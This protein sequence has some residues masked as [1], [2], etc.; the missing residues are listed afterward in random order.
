VLRSCISMG[1]YACSAGDIQ[2]LM[3]GVSSPSARPPTTHYSNMFCLRPDDAP[4]FRISDVI[5]ILIW[6]LHDKIRWASGRMLA[7]KKQDITQC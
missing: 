4:L 7:K 2:V 6:N 3:E 5:C 1:L